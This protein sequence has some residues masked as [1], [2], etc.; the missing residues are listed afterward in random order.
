M[1]NNLAGSDARDKGRITQVPS[2]TNEQDFLRKDYT[3]MSDEESLFLTISTVKEDEAT[4]ECLCAEC[5]PMPDR[6]V[7]SA[8]DH[9][10][11]SDCV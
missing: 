4:S 5:S 10:S 3:A 9:D 7:E 2:E 11:T 1:K 6:Y 8:S